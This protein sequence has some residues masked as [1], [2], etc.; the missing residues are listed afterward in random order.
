VGSWTWD[1]KTHLSPFLVTKQDFG[2]LVG[3]EIDKGLYE[4][5]ERRFKVR[6]IG[7]E[8]YVVWV[9][10][11]RWEWVTPGIKKREENRGWAEQ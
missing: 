2:C 8:D 1:D 3:Y 11:E 7:C 5:G 9:F 4:K 10:D 6:A